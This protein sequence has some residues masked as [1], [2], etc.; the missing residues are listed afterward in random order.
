MDPVDR[1]EPLEIHVF[2]VLSLLQATAFGYWAF[3]WDS[4]MI[5]VCAVL[6]LSGLAR[7]DYRSALKWRIFLVLHSFSALFFVAV[8]FWQSHPG[9]MLRPGTPDWWVWLMA[10]AGFVV[11]VVALVTG[12]VRRVWSFTRPPA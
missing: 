6:A 5:G 4:P 9:G 8:A 3:A 1:K 10:S 12:R 7:R 2:R 11:Q